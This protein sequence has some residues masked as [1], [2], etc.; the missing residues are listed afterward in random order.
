MKQRTVLEQ[1]VTPDGSTLSLAVRDGEYSLLVNGR[2][3]MSTRH[4][5]S[6]TQLAV[7][8]CEP[9]RERRGVRV[10]V[11]GL[12][13]GFTLR[14]ALRALARD[15]CVVVAELVAEV[16]EWNRNRQYPL[17]ADAL[18][19][20]R[21]R[22]VLGD[23][24]DLLAASAGEF[25]AILLDADN[26]TTTMNTAGNLRLYQPAGLA[27]VHRALK[28]AGTV[29]YW[30]ASDDPALAR[31]LRRAGFTVRATRV[32]QHATAGGH[33]TLYLGRRR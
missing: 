5:H 27:A 4:C 11:G 8:V 19:D 25:D 28:S 16:V 15:A 21:T 9:L 10:L 22:V 26:Q 18:A 1:T 23:V 17:A 14:A 32:R 30:S 20:R 3:L 7:V 12:G 2:E 33:H 24:A 13:L 31:A 6:E 29:A